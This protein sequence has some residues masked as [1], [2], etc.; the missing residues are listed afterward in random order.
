MIYSKRLK[1]EKIISCLKSHPEGIF[2]KF[3]ASETELDFNTVRSYLRELKKDGIITQKYLR[4]PYDFVGNTIHGLGGELPRMQNIVFTYQ[5]KKNIH[6]RM[7]FTKTLQI[8]E[9]KLEAGVKSNKITYHVHAKESISIRE[10][11]LIGQI[12]IADIHAY[13]DETPKSPEILVNT[14]EFNWDYYGI[15]IEGANCITLDNFIG[16]EKLYNKPGRIRYEIK[17]KIP[18]PLDNLIALIT[19]GVEYTSL[20]SKVSELQKSIDF[21]INEIK[22]THNYFMKLGGNRK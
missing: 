12:F 16:L 8:A 17:T 7:D 18:F 19:N 22:R 20:N 10:A 15:R 5:A 3:I 11:W 6:Q 4:G 14:T 21:A 9:V 13:L 2:A 1:I